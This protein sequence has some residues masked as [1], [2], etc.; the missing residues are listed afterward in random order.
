MQDAQVKKTLQQQQ[1]DQGLYFFLVLFV[2][3]FRTNTEKSVL[4]G[5]SRIDKT[6]VLNTNYRLMQV[7]SIAECSPLEPLNAGQKYCRMLPL[8][9]FCNT[10]DLH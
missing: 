1:P 4:S 10:F 5:H 7:K 9:A 3:I 2:W 8:G 6:K